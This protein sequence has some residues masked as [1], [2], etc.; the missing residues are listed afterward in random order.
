MEDRAMPQYISVFT[1]SSRS[2]S[3]IATLWVI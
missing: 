3:V 1:V 2:F